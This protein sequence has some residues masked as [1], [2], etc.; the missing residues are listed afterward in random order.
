VRLL[1]DAD[2]LCLR[3]T[4]CATTPSARAGG[5]VRLAGL[6]LCLHAS[7]TGHLAVQLVDLH[8]H[9][10]LSV[11]TAK[12]AKATSS[13]RRFCR[14]HCA[15]AFPLAIPSARPPLPTDRGVLGWRALGQD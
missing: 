6:L 5:R 2:R 7:M 4:M 12:V 9:V 15:S 10:G 1:S 14:P 8:A 11:A 13:S 3:L